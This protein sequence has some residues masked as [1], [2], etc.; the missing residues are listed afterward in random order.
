MRPEPPVNHQPSTLPQHADAQGRKMGSATWTKSCLLCQLYVM[1]SFVIWGSL[2][3]LKW[4]TNAWLVIGAKIY[5]HEEIPT[6]DCPFCHLSQSV[7]YGVPVTQRMNLQLPG[8]SGVVVE[9]KQ[10]FKCQFITT[11]TEQFGIGVFVIFCW[12]P[13]KQTA[14]CLMP[15]KVGSG[16]IERRT[17]T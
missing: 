7:C 9:I 17:G 10:R 16:K 5:T 8:H 14:K 1:V 4:S 2:T 3:P 11:K 6:R 13:G 12:D 15:V